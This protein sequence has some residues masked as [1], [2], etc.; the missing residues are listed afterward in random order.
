MRAK[1]AAARWWRRS[2]ARRSPARRTSGPTPGSRSASVLRSRNSGASVLATYCEL[3]ARRSAVY[4]GAPVGDDDL[5]RRGRHEHRRRVASRSALR[6][7]ICLLTSAKFA[8]SAAPRTR[9]AARPAGAHGPLASGAVSHAPLFSSTTS[10]RRIDEHVPVGVDGD[11]QRRA[12]RPAPAPARR[13]TRPGS[14][15]RAVEDASAARRCSA[16]LG[17]SPTRVHAGSAAPCRAARASR[18]H[19]GQRRA[20][21]RFEALRP[22]R[23]RP[24]ETASSYQ[25]RLRSAS[26]SASLSRSTVAKATSDRAVGS[27]PSRPSGVTAI[28]MRVFSVCRSGQEMT[29]G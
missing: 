20:D 28:A 25:L 14:P 2:T 15:A 27:A 7:G 4:C 8:S 18:G 26:P 5:G 11:R 23:C 22:A 13:R 29:C 3:S 1:S 9:P 24:P 6:P 19:R 17:A 21:L 16:T 12:G 10:C